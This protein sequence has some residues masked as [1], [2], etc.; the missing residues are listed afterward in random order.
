MASNKLT[1]GSILGLGNPLLDFVCDVDE[2]FLKKWS[3]PANSAILADPVCFPDYVSSIE[4]LNAH[5]SP[6][7][8]A[9]GD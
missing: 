3:L 2:D 6:R 1:S 5:A 7:L 9:L 8:K 4:V